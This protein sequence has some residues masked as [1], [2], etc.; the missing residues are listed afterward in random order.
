MAKVWV[1]LWTAKVAGSVQVEESELQKVAGLESVSKLIP[2]LVKV[3]DLSGWE[4]VPNWGKQLVSVEESV[5]VL[6]PSDLAKVQDLE[7]ELRMAR[8]KVAEW[9]KAYPLG[10]DWA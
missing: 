5:E 9:E 1:Q 10:K 3:S 6:E 8:A 4:T 7:L 2:M